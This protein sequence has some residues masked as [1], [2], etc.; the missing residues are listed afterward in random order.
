MYGFEKYLCIIKIHVLLPK[1]I[2]VLLL[3]LA[4]N[5]Y[6]YILITFVKAKIFSHYRSNTCKNVIQS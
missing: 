2:R 4:I 3:E 5:G 1:C 6:I